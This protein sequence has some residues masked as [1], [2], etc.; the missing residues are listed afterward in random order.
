MCFIKSDRNVFINTVA[1]V[2]KHIFLEGDR[3]EFDLVFDFLLAEL[4]L[5]G[6]TMI[7]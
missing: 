3:L 1:H 5:F 4:K 7:K 6:S 2:S